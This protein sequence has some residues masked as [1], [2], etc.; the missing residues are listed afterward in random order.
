M[1]ERLQLIGRGI[2]ELAI[3]PESRLNLIEARFKPQLN[4]KDRRLNLLTSNQLDFIA[5]ILS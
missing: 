3:M 2:P 5:N 1:S 4:S